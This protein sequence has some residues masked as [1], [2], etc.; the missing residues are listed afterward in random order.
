MLK[1]RTRGK[2]ANL[3]KTL[4]NKQLEFI[5]E[6]RVSIMLKYDTS[7]AH[8]KWVTFLDNRI[9]NFVKYEIPPETWVERTL[10]LSDIPPSITRERC[11]LQYGDIEGNKRWKEYCDRQSYTNT[12]EFKRKEYGWTDEDFDNFNK[13]RAVTKELCIKRHGKEEGLKIWNN[14]CEK[15]SYTNSLEY[16][17]EKYGIKEG[18]EKYLIY[19][20]RKG[21]TLENFILK[22]EDDGFEK[23]IKFKENTP[24]NFYSEMSQELFRNIEKNVKINSNIYYASKN[25]EFGKYNTDLKQYTYFDFVIPEYKICIEFNGNVF[26]ANPKMF[27]ENDCPNPWKKELTA[28][29][30]WEFDKKKN[31]FIKNLGFDVIIVWEE[32]YVN[33]KDTITNNV[34]SYIKDKIENYR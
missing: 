7:T 14:Y 15:Q 25:K 34:I 16:F 20:K 17:I 3:L 19:N 8:S 12:K 1:Y 30:I 21:I 18:K 22:Y 26:Y 27:T 4:S 5:E 23:Y 11:L 9:F 28:R 33:D 6:V 31:N 13:S 29:E 2:A 24:N 32:D 10:R